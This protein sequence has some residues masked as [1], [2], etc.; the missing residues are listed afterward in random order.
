MRP[1]QTVGKVGNI[2]TNRAILETIVNANLGDEVN[3][4]CERELAK[5]DKAAARNDQRK[6]AKQAENQP[7]LDQIET[8][9]GDEPIVA[10]A[11]AAELGVSTPKASALLRQL[12]AAG[13]AN[14]SDV[15]SPNKGTCKGY[16]KA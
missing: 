6:A 16:T 9:L 12:V 3:A 11:V 2:M 14:V 4:Y 15:K 7:L 1:R 8:M 13:I 10:S 5:L